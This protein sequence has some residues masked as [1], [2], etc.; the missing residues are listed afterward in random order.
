M[1]IS[2]FKK[3][4]IANR[5]E[6]A[7]RVIRACREL[8]ILS[9]AIYPSPDRTSLHVRMADEAYCLGEDPMGYLNTEKIV[10][11]AVKSNTCAIHPG[12]GFLSENPEFAQVCEQAGIVFI[13]PKPSSIEKMG[14]KIVARKLM[15]KSG[16]P[17]VPGS[18]EPLQS[19]EQIQKLAREIG[20]PLLLKPAEGG[21][22]KGMV[23]V[24]EESEL[25]QA[26]QSS[27][28]ISKSAFGSDLVYAEKYVEQ[29]R[30]VEVQILADS[31]GK[32]IHLFERECSVQRRHQK[33]IEETPSVFLNEQQRE[34]ICLKAVKAAVAIDYIG[35]GTVEFIIDK[36]HNFYFMEMNTRLQVEHPITEW[37]TGVDIVKEQIRIAQGEKLL[38]DQNS[39]SQKG[40]SLECRIYAE[41]AE[42]NFMPSPGRIH[43]LEMAQGPFIRVD[44]AIYEGYT[45]PQFYDPLIAKLSVWSYNR[46]AA[47]SKM[48][49]SLNEFKIFGIK[50]T[51]RFLID[52]L[53]N[54]DFKEGRY[55]THLVENHLKKNGFLKKMTEDE[56][57]CAL[58]ASGICAYESRHR[59][60]QDKFFNTDASSWKGVSR[61]ESLRNSYDI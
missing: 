57:T 54:N 2:R 22:G 43:H 4:L 56:I 9:V 27:R 53:N 40:H 60:L 15:H 37:V 38:L 44:S 47:I 23:L 46:S 10:E 14:H 32:T 20:F 28:R 48:I 35:A 58:I 52:L 34:D 50:T 55:D 3:I 36:K 11:S 26:F 31:F 61:R 13:G 49:S 8:G 42:N 21:G 19:A 51:E 29:P 24:R 18:T 6:I 25:Q 5:G 7:V 33:I 39:L 30:H 1:A 17:I 59:S 12:Y 16:V 41:D 45:V